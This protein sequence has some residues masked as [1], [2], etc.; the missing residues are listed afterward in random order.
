MALLA[1]QA[2][3]VQPGARE[4]EPTLPEGFGALVPDA[5]LAGYLYFKQSGGEPFYLDTYFLGSDGA[6]FP[7]RGQL[8]DLSVWMG[9]IERGG[10]S[11]VAAR[12]SFADE[13]Q[14]AFAEIALQEAV[15][16]D[17]LWLRR[18][19]ATLDVVVGRGVNAA[20]LRQAVE[21][22][23][24]T[25]LSAARTGVWNTALAL[26]RTAAHQP[27]AAGFLQV[28]QQVL[29]PA[30]G[31]LTRYTGLDVQPIAGLFSQAA[32]GHVAFALYGD[33]IP[34]LSFDM[35]SAGFSEHRLTA[36]V[37]TDTGVPAPLLAWSFNL[38]S[39]RMGMTPIATL[40]GRAYMYQNE[41][42]VTLARTGEG[43]IY[44]ALAFSE[45]EARDLLGRLGP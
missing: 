10:Y 6:S 20:N 25:T 30:F 17:E 19:A 8:K 18:E 2:A 22:Q 38:G 3:C 34:P 28:P 16:E 21:S 15:E 13:L 12:M 42:L 9:P 35:T 45:A 4:G 29:P 31:Y 27:V 14:A 23:R 36:L 5:P 24:F 7:L 32:V 26:P 44:A 11:A 39:Q 43:T 33:S 1:L 37:V 40:G 41:D